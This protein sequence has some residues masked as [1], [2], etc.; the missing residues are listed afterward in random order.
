MLCEECQNHEAVFT[1]TLT[2]GEGVTRKHL[3]GECMKKMELNLGD[4][5]IHS[6]LS[7]ILSIFSSAQ[8]DETPVCSGCGLRYSTF[9]K[10]GKLGCPQCYQDFAD[11]LTP[12]LGRIH[13]NTRHNGCTPRAMEKDTAAAAAAQEAASPA[14]AETP[15]KDDVSSVEELREE[16]RRK[17]EQAV[18]EENFED[19][20]LYR[21]QLKALTQAG[22]VQ[23]S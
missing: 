12:M 19:A 16:L 11:K 9:E 8:A 18:L 13:G 5:D 22:E 15:A 17:M 3:C 14:D 23:E 4:G 6:F 1:V 2:S 21:D 10:T 20:A 7:S